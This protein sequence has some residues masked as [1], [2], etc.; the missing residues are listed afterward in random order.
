MT[1][2]LAVKLTKT[3]KL[4]FEGVSWLSVIEISTSVIFGLA[5]NHL[6][7]SSSSLKIADLLRIENILI[8]FM[9]NLHIAT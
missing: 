4:K 5:A 1:D 2:P 3:D 7:T 8:C 9:T 6:F